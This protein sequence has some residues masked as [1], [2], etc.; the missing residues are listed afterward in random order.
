[1]AISAAGAP[2]QVI[3]PLLLGRPGFVIPHAGD[4]RPAR[5]QARL[6]VQVSPAGVT[7]LAH[8]PQGLAGIYGIA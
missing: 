3:R 2:Q 5:A 7:A 4:A 6:Q 8:S 1:M